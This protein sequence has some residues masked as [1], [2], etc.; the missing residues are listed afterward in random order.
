MRGTEE[1]W[2]RDFPLRGRKHEWVPPN[3]TKPVCSPTFYNFL[4][5]GPSKT[6][7]ARDPSSRRRT[8]YG[9]PGGSES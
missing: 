5:P 2:D 6:S 4:V 9:G 7:A 3:S 1:R 8:E